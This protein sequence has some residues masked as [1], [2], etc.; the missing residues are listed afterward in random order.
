M[1]KIE[2]SFNGHEPNCICDNCITARQ[3]LQLIREL[4]V[5]KR[6]VLRI[7]KE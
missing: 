2:L 4:K 7:E 6:I 3:Q 1:V 5:K